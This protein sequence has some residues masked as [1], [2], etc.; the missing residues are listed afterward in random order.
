VADLG[1]FCLREIAQRHR[2]HRSTLTRLRVGTKLFDQKRKPLSLERGVL[3]PR[4]GQMKELHVR[5]GAQEQ[6]PMRL[7]MLRVSKEIAD[8]RRQDLK[9]DAQRRKPPVS[10]EALREASWTIL[11][12]DASAKRLPFQ[13]ALVRLARKVADGTA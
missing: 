2:Q 1:Y 4:V 10:E 7:L 6:V 13:A 11:I 5:V 9:A 3:P 12:T 8:Q